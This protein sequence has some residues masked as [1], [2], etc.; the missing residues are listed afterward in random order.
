MAMQTDNLAVIIL[1]VCG[2]GKSVV[3]RALASRLDAAFV[4]ADDFHSTYN[5]EKMARGQALD[6]ADR[7]PWLERIGQHAAQ[8]RDDHGGVVVACSALK[9]SYRT[10]LRNHLAGATFI[11]LSA[12]RQV[13]FDRLQDRKLHFVGPNLLDSQL[14]VLEPLASDEDGLI[15]ECNLPV[16]DTITGLVEHLESAATG[17]FTKQRVVV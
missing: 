15:F 12:D 5:K 1:G 17:R 8:A 7:K 3:G 4:E 13:L 10:A 2:V 6:D 16:A 9:R 11:Q 14:A